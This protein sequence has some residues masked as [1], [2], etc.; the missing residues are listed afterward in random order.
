[1]RPVGHA[2]ERFAV[3]ADST[4]PT[5]ILD[6]MRAP[7]RSTIPAGL[8]TG[9]RPRAG[10]RSH[11]HSFP[12]VFATIRANASFNRGGNGRVLVA[13]RSAARWARG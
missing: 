2:V 8:Q 7:S 5:G 1:M 11:A 9:L 6:G 13:I 12:V 3:A 4:Y 10:A